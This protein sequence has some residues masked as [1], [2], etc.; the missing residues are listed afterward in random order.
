MKSS[1]PVSEVLNLHGDRIAT[2]MLKTKYGPQS[3]FSFL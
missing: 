2:N 1:F 3:S